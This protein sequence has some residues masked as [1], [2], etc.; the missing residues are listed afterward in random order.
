MNKRADRARIA[1]GSFEM[2]DNLCEGGPEER[3]VHHVHVSS[4]SM[5]RTLV[6]VSE[7]HHVY[8]WAS[9]H[10]YGFSSR[11]DGK[12]QDHPVHGINWYD[13]VKWCNARAEMQGLEPAYYTDSNHSMLYRKDE[14][15]LS[16]S[17]VMW[18]S[19]GYRLPTEAEW[20]K[21]ARGGHAGWRFPSGDTI[22]PRDACYDRAGRPDGP[23]E[24]EQPWT[25]PVASYAPNDF[26]LYDMAGNLWEWCWDWYDPCWYASPKASV[27]DN[28]G[29]DRGESRVMRGGSWYTSQVRLRCANR[30][31]G[32]NL[33]HWA[34]IHGGFRW[35]TGEG[36]VAGVD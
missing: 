4:F 10:G 33:P 7:W 27:A 25:C 31:R 1:A 16:K 2:G 36:S 13:A 26:G 19:S 21:A 28:H 32:N 11:G 30:Y 20:E 23:G 6:T 14:V 15:N 3:P 35:V 8:H 34:S 9:M 29:P 18:N 5:G 24:G 22:S 12:G 17:W